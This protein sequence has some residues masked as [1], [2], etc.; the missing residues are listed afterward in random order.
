MSS[1][2]QQNED[3]GTS[4]YKNAHKQK[5]T[6]TCRCTHSHTDVLSHIH[7]YIQLYSDTHTHTYL[8]SVLWELM[9]SQ[10]LTSVCVRERLDCVL[11]LRST[12]SQC[13][14]PFFLLDRSVCVCRCLIGGHAPVL[15]QVW[16][17]PSINTNQSAVASGS[18]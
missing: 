3:F 10:V 5:H 9:M 11:S 17:L 1:L 2:C 15:R 16:R 18:F 13:D 6:H 14:S 8:C 12:R 7:T 4:K